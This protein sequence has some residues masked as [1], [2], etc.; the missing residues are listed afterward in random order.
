MADEET[1]EPTPWYL[2][3]SIYAPEP[4][5]GPGTVND[6]MNQPDITGKRFP[7]D[8]QMT[9]EQLDVLPE[10][11]NTAKMIEGFAEPGEGVDGPMMGTLRRIGTELKQ[12]WMQMSTS[13]PME[14]GSQLQNRFP[15]VVEVRLAINP[16][17]DGS[18]IPVARNKLTGYEAVINKPGITGQ[19]V[20]QTIGLVGQYLPAAKATTAVKALAPRIATAAGSAF[21]T[22]TAIQAGQANLGGEFDPED[23][24]LATA[25][26]AVPEIVAKPAVGLA[27]KTKELL[28]K[29]LPDAVPATIRSALAFAEKQGYKITSSD[30]LQEFLTAPQRI[31]LKIT[32]RIPVFGTQRIKNTQKAQRADA[33]KRMADE[34]GIDIETDLGQE[35]AES[36]MDR[37]K[38][39][40]FFGKH[41]DPTD[42]MID[43]AFKKEAAEVV[44]AT[45]KRK[46][47]GATVE[48]G[49][50]DDVL[51]DTVFKGNKPQIVRD[52]MRKLT[53]EGQDAARRRFIQQGLERTGY[54]PGQ[55]VGISNPGAFVKYLD[56]HDKIIKEL[57][58]DTI[59]DPKKF[60]GG[61]YGELG[62][63]AGK[64][65]APALQQQREYLEGFKEFLRITDDAEK[66][67]AGAGM[68]AAMAAGG[69][70]YL[71]DIMGGALAGFGTAMAGHAMQ[72]RLARN[73]FLRLKHAKGNPE[74]QNSIMRELRPLVLGTGNLAL[75]EGVDMPM[76]NMSMNPDMIQEGAETGSEAAMQILRATMGTTGEAIGS[77]MGRSRGELTE[78]GVMPW[79][80]GRGSLFQGPGMEML[81]QAA[82]EAEAQG[83]PPEE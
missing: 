40:R 22:E 6:W 15:D 69:G 63:P 21:A 53:P 48:N 67:S 75:Q 3:E 31:F 35:I 61:L 42:E 39:W 33:L 47:K 26:S 16:D 83:L 55:Q 59:T 5:K 30:A 79:D 64:R 66:A 17:G 54:R 28:A 29:N 46:I 13:D 10:M 41:A 72:S 57:F 51:V 60:P 1:L 45:L 14:L 34:F 36:F 19:D 52:F 68:T 76:L 81:R 71:F 70:F 32:E 8:P 50:I 11:T 78:G 4:E 38:S 74:M 44:D 65:P 27:L 24:A 62:Q 77:V 18:Y 25:F 58:P 9:A 12:G 82:E 7:I 2:D 49:N 43:R 73:L 20:L 80:V 23:V 37:M 56:E